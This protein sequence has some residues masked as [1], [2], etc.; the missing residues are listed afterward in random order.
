MVERTSIDAYKMIL[1]HLG[2]CAR[3]VY[4]VIFERPGVCIGKIGKALNMENSTVSGRVNDLIA[5]GLVHYVLDGDG[6]VTKKSP[7]SGISVKVL[8]AN[9]VFTVDASALKSK[10][11][12]PREVDMNELDTPDSFKKQGEFHL[13]TRRVV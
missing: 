8:R 9:D 4:Q 6:Y 10:R 1:E 12:A 5:D 2:D 7:V 11:R 13:E 3:P